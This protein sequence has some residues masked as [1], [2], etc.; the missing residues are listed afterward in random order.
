[1]WGGR[2]G[3]SFLFDYEAIVSQVALWH[4]NFLFDNFMEGLRGKVVTFFTAESP[5]FAA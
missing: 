2:H 4:Y 3:N 1:V 5:V